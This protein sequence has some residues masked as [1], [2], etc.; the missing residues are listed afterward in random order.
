VTVDQLVGDGH[1]LGV[2][3]VLVRQRHDGVRMRLGQGS[4]GK[5]RLL[6]GQLGG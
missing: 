2:H 5:A 6:S 1:D 4:S 3:P